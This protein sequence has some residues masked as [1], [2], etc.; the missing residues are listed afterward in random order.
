MDLM[1]YLIKG[2][3]V[4][5][6]LATLLIFL[7]SFSSSFA[8][9]SGQVY[10][11][12][13]A[14]YSTALSEDYLSS[15][16]VCAT[17]GDATDYEQLWV[18]TSSGSGYTLQN[19]YTGHYAQNMTS[20]YTPYNTGA[21][22]ATFYITTNSYN[23]SYYNILN[24][25][26]ATNGMHCD[27]SGNVVLWSVATKAGVTASE[28]SFTQVSLTSAQITA[29]RAAYAE[30]AAAQTNASS[31]YATLQTIFIDAACTT[32]NSTSA[33]MTDAQLRS[34]LSSL[35]TA[36]Q[37]MA[38]KIKNNSWGTYEQEFRER[39]YKPYSDANNWG[40]RLNTYKYSYM[41][42][43]TG[44]YANARDVLY[45]FVGGDVPAD[46]TLY[47]AGVTD[48]NIISSAT[49]GTALAKGLNVVPVARD[50]A[51]QYILYTVDTYNTTKTISDFSNLNIHIEG[52]TV[53][54]FWEK[55]VHDDA[56]WV[57]YKTFCT[58]PMILVKGDRIMFD[59]HKEYIM[60]D[61]C[62]G[63]TISDAIGWWDNLALWDQQLLG[64]I[65]DGSGV[66]DDYYPSHFNNLLCARSLTNGYQ[67]ASSYA[68]QFAA[69]YIHNLLP[70]SNMMSAG[71][72][73]WGP[74]HENG[75]VHQGAI[76]MVGCSEVSNN[77]FSNTII[78]K[79]GKYMSRGGTLTQ[80]A[81]EFNDGT[82]WLKRSG[83]SKMRM[84]WQLYLYYHMAGNNTN[85][86][87]TLFKLL[88]ADPLVKGTNTDGAQCSMKFVEKCCQAAGEDLTDFFTAWGFFVPLNN[89]YCNDYG[90][91][92]VTLTQSEI[93]A[94]KA[95]ISAYTQK[96]HSLEFIE[97]RI[98]SI[99]RTDGVSG[100][101]VANGVA[102]GAAGSLG[103]YTDFV[104]GSTSQ[105]TGYVYSQAGTTLT[106]SSGTGGVGFAVYNSD[107]DLVGFSN[108]TT[109]TLTSSAAAAAFT[110]KAV[111]GDGSVAV[112]TSATQG[113]T[114]QQ[115]AALNANITAANAYLDLEDADNTKPGYYKSSALATLKSLVTQ[116]NAT[117]TASNSA[118]YSSLAQQISDELVSLSSATDIKTAIVEGN[119]YSLTNV[120][121]PSYS[122]ALSGTNLTNTTAATTTDDKKWGFASTGTSGQ[123]YIYNKAGNY[124]TTVPTSATVTATATATSDALTFNVVDN[125]DGSFYMM[126]AAVSSNGSLHC[127]ASHQ[128]V[129][130]SSSATA[131]H[132]KLNLTESPLIDA[133]RT[134]LQA[135]IEAT[136][137]LL[138]QCGTLSTTSAAVTLQ[139]TD[140]SAAGYLSTNE[141][142]SHEGPIANLIDGS[143]ST[144][145]HSNYSTA[146]T[147]YHYLQ[148]DL[149]LGNSLTNF[150]F[151]YT[152]RAANFVNKPTTLLV[153]GS[154][155]GT[156]FTVLSTLSSTDA[157]NPLPSNTTS[158]Q[159]YTS[160]ALG[161]GTAYRYLRFTVTSTNNGATNS[162]SAAYPFF[163]L[164]QF[165]LSNCVTTAAVNAALVQV[166]PALM[167]QANDAKNLASVMYNNSA[168]T[169]AQLTQ[170]TTTLQTA[171]D[172][173]HEVYATA[174]AKYPF[175]LTLD[176]THPYLYLI[177]VPGRTGGNYC[178]TYT[179]DG[180]IH[181]NN[182]T[183]G[184]ENMLWYF[185]QASNGD[186][187]IIPYT[188]NSKVIGSNDITE[189]YGK[190]VSIAQGTSGYVTTWKVDTL[191]SGYN[192][193]PTGY[194][195]IY[196]SNHSNVAYDMGFYSKN[197][198]AGSLFTFEPITRTISIGSV[199]Y[200]T[201]Y[202]NY[203]SLVPSGVTA[204]YCTRSGDFAVL[205][206]VGS[207]LPA[208]TGVVLTGDAGNYTFFYTS[209]TNANADAIAAANLLKGSTD[210]S[211]IEYSSTLSRYVLGVV[212]GAV[213]FYLPLYNCNATGADGTTHFLN[214]A[215]KAYLEVT[216]A[217]G[218]KSFL[219]GRGDDTAVISPEA[220]NSVSKDTVIYDLTGRRIHK[221]TA[222]GLYI[223]NGK[224][225]FI[226]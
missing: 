17:A 30:L 48:A 104:S 125:G 135:L 153:S 136:E 61:D 116:A 162:G 76:N 90:D 52:G 149:G 40:T 143:T 195:S 36:L 47:L 179:T 31:Y 184:N 69:S 221:V 106:M 46:A 165:S 4:K 211:Y 73:A 89:V 207:V 23:S 142:E 50:L 174:T 145:F 154:N 51:M 216:G 137:T 64:I 172:A 57:A 112:L 217:A 74:A 32:L 168:A 109:I 53:N 93:D 63:S 95:T 99:A 181:L 11:I 42:N 139:T 88:R 34:A 152:T 126:N 199:G 194:T 77:L 120:N 97:D 132:W 167:L 107:G 134:S 83:E 124:I 15:K 173:L 19:V 33:A 37:N 202:L 206:D 151:A 59:M 54:G 98:S 210:N 203:S 22:A 164:S 163:T 7:C 158:Q 128:M 144:Y 14:N 55:G 208:T 2:R 198:V 71:D 226:R 113:T 205:H 219:F 65:D 28:W 129:G 196:L 72:N 68:T 62:C 170:A 87:P 85:F 218:V 58:H 44:I 200:A 192:F 147:A 121:Y 186:V 175:T 27:N 101:K 24:N 35:P 18:V 49:A 187:L 209:T 140:A 155:D 84:Y 60:A 56:R 111:N 119:Y 222:R 5:N 197:N 117:V 110:V 3:S 223:V 8:I 193:R 130:W 94:T 182:Y 214:N 81:Q 156:N 100:N 123:Y 80:M 43:P 191:A 12:V 115:L 146:S 178:F 13:N 92:Y 138:G 9:T 159:S 82:P 185:K 16:L 66:N 131:S 70:Y 108:T 190:V 114:A 225:Y 118:L 21:T 169:L 150:S 10:R 176:D 91:Y 41:N 215:R 204:N 38:V 141:Q 133:A 127:D 6:A 79:L 96:N 177:R 29:A 67:S 20:L 160:A 102:V 189:G 86:Y 25:S 122:A 180:K 103:Q 45:V 220:D 78:Y 201:L 213:G 161:N 75:H 148:V 183:A 157:T 105:A 26:S 166:T 212:D 1:N 171:Y 224:K 39:S 188:D